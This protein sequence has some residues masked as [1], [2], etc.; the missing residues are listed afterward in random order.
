VLPD[1]R[2]DLPSLRAMEAN[3]LIDVAYLDLGTALLEAARAAAHAPSP[4]RRRADPERL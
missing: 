2:F 3:V 1:R 4:V